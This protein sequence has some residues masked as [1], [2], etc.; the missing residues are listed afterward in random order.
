[1]ERKAEPGEAAYPPTD[2]DPAALVRCE[3]AH[4]KAFPT[5]PFVGHR[6]PTVD[7]LRPELDRNSGYEPVVG[8]GSPSGAV[9]RLEY[10]H[11]HARPN[12][13]SGR[14]EAGE[15]G[16]D[17]HNV[18]MFRNRG[19]AHRSPGRATPSLIPPIPPAMT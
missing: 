14:G 13:T 7:H 17:D 18:G 1:M 6:C 9:P 10:L 15:A 16:A 2:D 3:G 5:H 19:F 8:E 12:E 11:A 4:G